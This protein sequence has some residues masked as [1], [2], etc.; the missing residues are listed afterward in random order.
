[1]KCPILINKKSNLMSADN[2]YGIYI[3]HHKYFC[4]NFSLTTKLLCTNMSMIAVMALSLSLSPFLYL[5]ALIN[6]SISLSVDMMQGRK[7]RGCG[8][9]PERVECRESWS[10]GWWEI[11]AL[12]EAAGATRFHKQ[13]AESVNRFPHSAG[14]AS[15]HGSATG[16]VYNQASW[17]RKYQC[18]GALHSI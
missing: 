10:K 5:L 13:G 8:R 18:K 16:P 4:F 12:R 14:T 9:E 3:I 2:Q 6:W 7:W 11:S 15:H 1:M 17:D